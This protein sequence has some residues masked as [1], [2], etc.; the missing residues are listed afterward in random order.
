VTPTLTTG[1]LV[2][3]DSVSRALLSPLAAPDLHAW[4]REVIKTTSALLGAERGQFMLSTA[5][6]VH[7]NETADPASL[8]ATAYDQHVE[9]VRRPR[10]RDAVMQRWVDERRRVGQEVVTNALADRLLAPHGLSLR[11]SFSYNEGMVPGGATAAR[12]TG[13]PPSSASWTPP[14]SGADA[15]RPRR[16]LS[17]LVRRHAPSPH[18]GR[19]R[20]PGGR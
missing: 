1:D 12:P 4:R 15:R 13:T 14:D 17:P 19:P 5:L 18:V 8:A 16:S 20:P 10:L 2:R 11:D 6:D 9:A 7:F 3:L